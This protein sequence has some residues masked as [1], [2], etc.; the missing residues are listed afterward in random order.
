MQEYSLGNVERDLFTMAFSA[1]NLLLPLLLFPPIL[2]A[3]PPLSGAGSAA[4]LAADVQ[5]TNN[6]ALRNVAGQLFA[7]GNQARAA[8]GLRALKWDPA[9]AAAALNHCVRMAAEGNISHQYNGEPD[10]SQR[11]GQA[12]AHFSFLEEN[13]AEGYAP[14]AIH[15]A[16]MHSPG[17]RENLLNPTVDRVGVAVVARGDMFYAVVDFEKA[18]QVL[19][20]EQVE[21]EVANLVEATGVA[22]HGN[23]VGA[24]LACSQDHGMPA[25]LDNKRPEFIMRWQDAEI[26]RLPDALMDKIASGRYHEAAI[27]SCPAQTREST[28][29]VYRVAV[30]L[31]K[32]ES[33]GSR[34]YLSSK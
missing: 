7:L 25:S 4:F 20:R 19:T 18:V 14:A 33:S 6:Q 29:T 15:Q 8:Q 13:V 28:F 30:L 32:P 31:L 5:F 26:D 21:A 22:A 1:K 34:T 11:A 27:G 9:L 23:S 2:A 16:W 12:G 10:L 3:Q 17:H 24:R